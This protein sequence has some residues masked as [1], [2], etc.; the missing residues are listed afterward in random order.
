M[1]SGRRATYADSKQAHLLLG[2]E[3]DQ[4][5][6]EKGFLYIRESFI[7]C[8]PNLTKKR[9]SKVMPYGDP[10]S[11]IRSM[12]G[13]AEEPHLVRLK[14]LPAQNDTTRKPATEN[15]LLVRSVEENDSGHQA[16]PVRINY[17]SYTGRV[18]FG[19]DQ[20]VSYAS[21]VHELAYGRSGAGAQGTS[22]EIGYPAP[23]EY[24]RHDLD[25]FV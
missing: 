16:E 1:N 6:K 23:K 4:E 21:V 14:Y 18:S 25:I 10:L 3:A 12:K 19:T 8:L 20:M 24:V 17:T 5:D 22:G 9:T 15:A 2:C 11:H 13:I 7:F